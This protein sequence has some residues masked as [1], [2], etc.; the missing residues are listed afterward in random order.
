MSEVLAIFEHDRGVAAET[1]FQSL[2]FAR[3][4]LAAGV[5]SS[6][7]A[8][9]IGAEADALAHDLGAYGASSVVLIH[10][11]ELTDYAPEAW[12]EAVAEL[13]ALRS[14]AAVVATG[15]DR[16]NEVL[17]YASAIAD[18]P[19]AANVT[20][21]RS[22]GDASLDLTRVRWGGSLLERSKLVAATYVLSGAAHVF[23]GEPS[24]DH[25]GATAA[26]E[27]VDATLPDTAAR[28]RITDRVTLSSGI[29][30]TTAA[31]VVS[32]GRGV[33]SAEGFA[34][35]VELA[36]LLGGAVGCSRV[37][38]NNGWRPHSDQVGQTG[39][40]IAPELYIACGIS[41][42]IQHWVGMMA[43]KHVLA[44][45]TDGEANMVGKAEY[46]VIGDLHKI[47]PA[48][49]AEIRKRRTP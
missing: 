43:S 46:A 33:G 35:L 42:A 41:G 44:I 6:I 18:L 30:L 27:T 17:A 28:T 15:T 23:D 38:T 2:G 31:V 47:L 13:I 25:I 14:P 34:P 32:G 11:A 7:T 8:V 40:R 24:P 19:F 1:S 48:V 37:V 21:I 39:K 4:L 9:V 29:T 10:H 36:D 16:G 26:T 49:S 45:N 5:G 12:G 22:V 3:A 20:E